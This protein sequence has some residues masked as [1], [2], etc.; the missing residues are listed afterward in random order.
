LYDMHGNVAEWCGDWFG[1]T[2]DLTS[3][4]DP[5]GAATGTRRVIRGGSWLSAGADC[6]CAWRGSEAPERFDS[7]L[8]F[9]VVAEIP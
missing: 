1:R 3:T 9:R 5:T 2:V 8:G 7:I 6:R 4:T